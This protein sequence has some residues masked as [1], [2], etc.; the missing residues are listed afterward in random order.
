MRRVSAAAARSALS[1]RSIWAT[2]RQLDIEPLH[3]W[4]VEQVLR[5]LITHW[6]DVRLSSAGSLGSVPQLHRYYADAPTSR[7]LSCCGLPYPGQDSTC[8]EAGNATAVAYGR[9]LV[10]SDGKLRDLVYEVYGPTEHLT[11]I[12]MT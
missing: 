4:L 2:V 11:F 1:A 6:P 10:T 7:R 8:R 5:P 3:C 9:T 12:Q